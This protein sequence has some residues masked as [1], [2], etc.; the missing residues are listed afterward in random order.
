VEGLKLDDVP[1]GVYSLSCLPLRLV[2]S[3][4]SP[5]R[6]ILITWWGPCK[7][8]VKPGFQLHGMIILRECAIFSILFLCII[9]I[10]IVL[11]RCWCWMVKLTQR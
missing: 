10:L 1:A 9:L 5:I 8:V 11:S 3:E 7:F 6:C 2:H 4:A